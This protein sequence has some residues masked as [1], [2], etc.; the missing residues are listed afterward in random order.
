M[1]VDTES[2]DRQVRAY[3]YDAVFTQ[4]AIP[5]VAA[6]ANGLART[7]GE[8]AAAFGRLARGHVLVL[9]QGGDEILMANPFSAVPTPFQVEAG[10]R[11]YWGNCLWDALGILAMLNVDGRL[12]ASCG[13]CGAA[14]TLAVRDGNVADAS[15]V[16]HF[17]VPAKHW[18]DNIVFT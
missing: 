8:I 14:M 12:L 10:G 18:W 7:P 13:D 6:T 9:Q 4:G 5:T 3:V 1:V 16:A 2:F 11:V 17:S 15:G